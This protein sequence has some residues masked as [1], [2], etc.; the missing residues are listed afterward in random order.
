MAA[1]AGAAPRIAAASSAAAAAGQKVRAAMCAMPRT[2]PPQ[3]TFGAATAGDS[4]G[5]RP[6]SARC[7]TYRRRRDAH[8]L[9]PPRG[10]RRNRPPRLAAASCRAAADR[11]EGGWQSGMAAVRVPAFATSHAPVLVAEVVAALAPA[12]ALAHSASRVAS[13]VDCTVG[14]GGHAAALLR[15]CALA[16]RVVGVDADAQAVATAAAAHRAL[17]EEGRLVLQHGEY[18]AALRQLRAEGATVDGVLADL[19]VSSFQLDAG[20]R[21]FSHAML[22]VSAGS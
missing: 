6:R 13:V 12:M 3:T 9:A 10:S 22:V 7:R 1:V 5:A 16:T 11:G 18:T 21:G 4:E 2:L 8:C 14:G 20:E 15:A 19:G 17:V